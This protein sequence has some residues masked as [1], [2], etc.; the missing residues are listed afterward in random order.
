M[1]NHPVYE[2][3]NTRPFIWYQYIQSKHRTVRSMVIYFMHMHT[4]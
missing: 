4:P 3:N 1:M 2:A